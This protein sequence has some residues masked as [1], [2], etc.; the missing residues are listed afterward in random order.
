MDQRMPS[1]D[2]PIANVKCQPRKE[3]ESAAAPIASPPLPAGGWRHA[4]AMISLIAIL[5]SIY[6]ATLQR[7]VS[8]GD[9]AEIQA[10]SPLLGI[11][12]APGYA[13][14][15]TCG[16]FVSLLPIGPDAAYR[17]NLLM[18]V[19]GIGGCLAVYGALRRITGRILPGLI[20]AGLLGFSS[21]Y[22]SYSLVAEAYVFHGAFLL[23]GAYAAVRFVKSDRAA[24]LWWAALAVGISTA[25]RP[26]ELFVLPGFLG[27]WLGCRRCVRL[28]A[29]RLGLALVLYLLPFVFSVGFFLLRD[30]PRYV[31][32]RDGVLTDE[33]LGQP[34]TSSL[35]GWPRLNGAIYYSLGLT[36]AHHRESWKD[37]LTTGSARYA[38]LLSGI[39]A[40]SAHRRPNDT[41][42]IEQGVIGAAIGLPGLLLAIAGIIFHR[43]QYGWTLLGLGFFLGNLAFCLWHQAWDANTFTVPGLAGLALLGGLGMAGPPGRNPMPDGSR[44][45]AGGRWWS[46]AGLAVGGLTVLGLAIGNYRLVDRSYLTDAAQAARSVAAMRELPPDSIVLTTYWPA[47]TNRY[48]AYVAAGRT[49]LRILAIDP[50]QWKQPLAYAG[51]HG[52]TLFV[53]DNNRISREERKMAL[54]R[55][56]RTAAEAGLLLIV[57]PSRRT[58]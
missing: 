23:F 56:P 57:P 32:A 19:C 34:S 4:L 39:D 53:I 38:H 30:N 8:R 13:I 49:D 6:L 58:P 20:A 41:L 17:I 43:R 54:S 37:R 3:T 2:K 35:S 47:T 11:C 18:A 1:S 15:I 31:H 33:I 52:R 10:L 27:L 5:G 51:R 9:S 26:S 28:T 45:A 50:K 29:P 22:W 16:Y 14:E 21:I 40:V 44:P 48:A 24:W 7:G 46:R 12:H 42:Q 25:G 55:T 36:W